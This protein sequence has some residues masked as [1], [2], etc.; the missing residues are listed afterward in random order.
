MDTRLRHLH[1]LP[2]DVDLIILVLDQILYETVGLDIEIGG[3]FLTARNDQRR[4]GFID[5]DGVDFVDQRDIERTEHA[6]M[7]R[8]DHVVAQIVEARFRIGRI[9]DVAQ[10]RITFLFRCHRPDIQSDAQAK[11]LVDGTHPLRIASGQVFVDRDDMDALPGQSIE[12]HR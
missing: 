3:L 4:S 6:V 12:V 7:D 2:F 11:E 1:G 5:Q 9:G 8:R 10:V